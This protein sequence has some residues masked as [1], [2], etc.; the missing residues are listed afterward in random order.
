MLH[1]P[2]V[3]PPLL[4]SVTAVVAKAPGAVHQHLLGQNPQGTCLEEE[5]EKATFKATLWR[6]EGTRAPAKEHNGGGR[7][8]VRVE[9]EPRRIVSGATAARLLF[10]FNVFHRKLN[11]NV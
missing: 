1:D 7:T 10:V 9:A 2:L 6:P 4:A 3:R 11:K 8:L 5:W